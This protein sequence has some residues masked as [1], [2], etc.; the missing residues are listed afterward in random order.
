[1]PAPSPSIPV[2]DVLNLDQAEWAYYLDLIEQR[3]QQEDPGRST[4]RHERHA[5]LEFSQ[6]GLVIDLNRK[7]RQMFLVRTYDLSHSGVG[8]LHGRYVPVDTTVH[9]MMLHRTDGRVVVSGTIRRC[10]LIEGH[11]HALGVEFNEPVEPG[12]YLLISPA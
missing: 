2:M 6:L 12:D 3:E 7:E 10:E 4:R 8:L 9:V 11:V 5:Y 1:M